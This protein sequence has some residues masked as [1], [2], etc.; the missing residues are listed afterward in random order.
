MI[1][2]AS[3]TQEKIRTATSAIT[4]LGLL[5]TIQP[6]PQTRTLVVTRTVRLGPTHH[7]VVRQTTITEIGATTLILNVQT[8][9]KME[10]M[11]DPIRPQAEELTKALLRRRDRRRLIGVQFQATE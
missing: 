2:S 9:V 3:L 6:F 7:G 1:Y 11:T 4:Q 5:A 8:D 10:S